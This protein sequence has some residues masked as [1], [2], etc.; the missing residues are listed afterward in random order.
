MSIDGEFAT[1][2]EH[3]DVES[4]ERI[5][6]QHPEMANASGWTPPPLH[7]AVLWNQPQVAEILLDHGAD[8]ESRDPDRQTTPLRYAILFAKKELIPIL[9]AHG[10]NAG[11]ISENGATAMELAMGALNGQFEEYDDLP[12]S[13]EYAEIVQVLQANGVT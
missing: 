8:V 5:L 6:L 7:C 10:A 3:G 2:I 4:V 13:S 12:R 9:L 1:A 11:P